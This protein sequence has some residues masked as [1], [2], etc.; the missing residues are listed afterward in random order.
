[1][2]YGEDGFGYEEEMTV[3][4]NRDW[5]VEY[6][7]DW[8]T[9]EPASGKVAAVG[10][11]EEFKV[12]VTIQTNDD[13]NI[14]NTVL[15]FRTSAVYTDVSVRQKENPF[16]SPRILYYNSFG[17][18]AYDSEANGGYPKM[19]VSPIWKVEDGASAVLTGV[20]YYGETA[21]VE[22][23]TIRSSSTSS[24]SGYI[25]ASGN[26]HIHFGSGGP[27]FT[28]ADIAVHEKLE[29][30]R[31][32]FG[33]LRNQYQGG[34]NNYVKPEEFP[35]WISKDGANWIKE[36]IKPTVEPSVDTWSLCEYEF[37]F[38]QA[39]FDKLYVR[40]KPTVA[41]TYRFDDLTIARGNAGV[42]PIDWSKATEAIDLSA[43]TEIN[44]SS[45]AE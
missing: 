19:T 16:N 13:G 43:D 42:E 20:K 15:R 18:G 3:Y 5:T 4:S 24:S 36:T 8:I 1:M 21:Y 9:V 30:I 22:K 35:I 38:P 14:R 25:G 45:S 12:K 28:L 10:E 26:N 11:K 17:K 27:A 44:P 39:S 23:L 40:F 37:S 32:S 31:I 41:S 6:D 2:E 29:A 33:L 34:N 7:A